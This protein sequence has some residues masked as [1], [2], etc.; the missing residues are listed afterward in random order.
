MLPDNTLSDKAYPAGFNFPV[1]SAADPDKLQAWELGG[2]GLNDASTG[3]TVKLWK[4]TIEVD[5]DTG[6]SHVFVQA[7]GVAKTL[8]FS[9]VGISEID[10][11]FDQNMN[12]FVAYTQGSDAKIYWYDPTVP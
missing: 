5:E 4:G 3:L 6:V 2:K 11:S 9:G 1:K 10:I 12:P 7:P 8:L